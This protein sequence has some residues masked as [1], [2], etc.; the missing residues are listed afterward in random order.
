MIYFTEHYCLLP[1]ISFDLLLWWDCRVIPVLLAVTR[2]IQQEEPN[3]TPPLL[4]TMI[5]NNTSKCFIKDVL[6]DFDGVV[7]MKDASGRYAIDVAIEME[8]PFDEGLKEI[9]EVTAKSNDWDILHCAAHHGLP[10]NNGMQKLVSGN[11]SKL[12]MTANKGGDLDT[13]NNLIRIDRMCKKK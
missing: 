4:H 9:L 12:L 1:N 3:K 6:N 11:I 2:H 7:S 8:L 13:F 5:L 10:W